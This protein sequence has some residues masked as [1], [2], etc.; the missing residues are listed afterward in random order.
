MEILNWKVG[1]TLA[2]EGVFV[3]GKRITPCAVS[4]D[5]APGA[6][7]VYQLYSSAMRQIL[8][9]VGVPE[10]RR[11]H[12]VRARKQTKKHWHAEAPWGLPVPRGFRKSAA[13]V[14]TV[15]DDWERRSPIV[16]SSRMGVADLSVGGDVGIEP[17]QL[18]IGAKG[19]A[20]LSSGIRFAVDPQVEVRVLTGTDLVDH[21]MVNLL[22]DVGYIEDRGDES[23]ATRI[24]L[25]RDDLLETLNLAYEPPRSWEMIPHT[26][27]L[28]GGPG[29]RQSVRVDVSTPEPGD[30]YMAVEYRHRADPE[31]GETS[32][33]WALS[34]GADLTVTANAYPEELPLPAREL[35]LA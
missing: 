3:P 4:A 33:V 23:R 29:E 10:R 5:P 19:R 1:D 15:D 26:R 21:M 34:V 17:G 2:G 18:V 12:P 7:Q 6:F 25:A 30:C 22:E 16:Y 27:E 32:D 31:V 13:F 24:E 8:K 9:H 11:L 28:S 35:A 14:F 20:S